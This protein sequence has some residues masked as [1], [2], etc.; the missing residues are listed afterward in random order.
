M[1][2]WEDGAEISAKK[3]A[4]DQTLSFYIDGMDSE[5]TMKDSGKKF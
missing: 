1:E 3:P 2:V 5:N 4:Q